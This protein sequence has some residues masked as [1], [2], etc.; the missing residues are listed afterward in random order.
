MTFQETVTAEE[1]SQ[2]MAKESLPDENTVDQ[3]LQ[4]K[5]GQQ[6]DNEIIDPTGNIAVEED[7]LN[8]NFFTNSLDFIEEEEADNWKKDNVTVAHSCF[9]LS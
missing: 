1:Q 9:I 7:S 2:R 4:G 5:I 3:L 6:A 8:D